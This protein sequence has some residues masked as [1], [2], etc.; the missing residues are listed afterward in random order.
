MTGFLNPRRGAATTVT[1]IAALAL[2]AGL[3]AQA[4]ALDTDARSDTADNVVSRQLA[5]T[6]AKQQ[7]VRDYWTA[8]RIAEVP[9]HEPSD[10]PPSPGPAGAAY[11]GDGAVSTTVGRLFYVG[12]GGEDSSC[13]ATV[14]ESANRS[15][16]VTAGHCVVTH[17][18]LGENARWAEQL[19]FVPGFRDGEMPHGAFPAVSGVVDARWVASG[20]A[21]DYDQS[22]LVLGENEE[23]ER[24]ADAVGAVQELAFDPEVGQPVQEFGYPRATGDPAQQGRPEFIG[25]RLAHCWGTSQALAD[26]P[27]IPNTSDTRGIPCDMGGGASGGPRFADFDPEAGTGAVVGLNTRGRYMNSA[28]EWCQEGDSAD[29]VRYLAGP[30]LTSAITGPLYERAHRSGVPEAGHHR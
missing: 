14:V 13:T 28:G 5:D 18:L 10:L 12:H 21:I 3:S 22:F 4:L 27:E 24:V 6:A 15:T 9:H 25:L 16:V 30:P 2:T 8:E 19:L 20:E 29:C 23:G 1:A 26:H 17:D 11:S 7:Q